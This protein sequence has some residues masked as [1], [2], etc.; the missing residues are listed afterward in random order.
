MNQVSP[1]ILAQCQ[2]S[3]NQHTEYFFIPFSEEHAAKYNSS[4]PLPSSLPS[5]EIS[6]EPSTP[7]SSLPSVLPSRNASLLPSSLPSY[8]PRVQPTFSPNKP[9]MIASYRASRWPSYV[10][11][12]LLSRDSDTPYP[13]STSLQICHLKHRILDKK[14]QM[15]RR[16]LQM[17]EHQNKDIFSG[18]KGGK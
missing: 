8:S 10:P 15:R 2:Y 9:S 12:I 1:I 17:K 13:T 11:R 4:S 16:K 18:H 14:R 5:D 3:R 6:F 7:L